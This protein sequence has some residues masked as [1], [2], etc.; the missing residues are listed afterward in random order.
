M[1]RAERWGERARSNGSTVL[2]DVTVMLHPSHRSRSSSSLVWWGTLTTRWAV[3]SLDAAGRSARTSRRRARGAS[4]RR[5]RRARLRPSG[6]RQSATSD[7]NDSKRCGGTCESPC[8]ARGVRSRA[9]PRVPARSCRAGAQPGYPRF[10]RAAARTLAPRLP[11]DGL[12][13]AAYRARSARPSV[14]SGRARHGAQEPGEFVVSS[15]T[16]RARARRRGAGTRAGKRTRTG[17]DLP[18][19][20]D[21]ARDL[22]L[23]PRPGVTTHREA[24]GPHAQ[25]KN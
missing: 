13:A 5:H 3:S 7:Q 19:H 1:D 17:A 16:S 25:E 4:D 12:R 21:A 14:P 2:G 22:R 24:R 6:L 8:V 20:A 18:P 11:S 15:L 10:A 9:G 23:R